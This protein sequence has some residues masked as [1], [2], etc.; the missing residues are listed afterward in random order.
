M[1]E[2]KRFESIVIK[3]ALGIENKKRKVYRRIGIEPELHEVITNNNLNL[4]LM[5]NY[6]LEKFLREKG[7]LK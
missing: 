4:T 6:A 2:E 1:A 3:R 5:V 7:Y